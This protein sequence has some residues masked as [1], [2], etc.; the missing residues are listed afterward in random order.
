MSSS[1]LRL[2]AIIVLGVAVRV[3]LH[4]A[5]FQEIFAV[6]YEVSTPVSSHKRGKYIESGRS[7]F[8]LFFFFILN[9]DYTNVPSER[10][11]H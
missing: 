9:R 2:L 8:R 1:A 7:V 3:F 11:E 6:S 5:G 10:H 4:L